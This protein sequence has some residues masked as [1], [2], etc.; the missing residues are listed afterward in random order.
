MVGL[1]AYRKTYHGHVW[2]KLV[3]HTLKEKCTTARVN[4]WWGTEKTWTRFGIHWIH[5][6]TNHAEKYIYEALEPIVRF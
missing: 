5:A 2:D 3:C 4:L 1:C 6:S